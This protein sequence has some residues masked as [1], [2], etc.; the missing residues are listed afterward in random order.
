[1]G[2]WFVKVCCNEVYVFWGRGHRGV[3]VADKEQLSASLEDYLEAIYQI[4][5]RKGAAQ[6]SQVADS[7][8]VSKSSVSWGLNRL[9]ER[10]LINHSPYEAITLTEQGEALGRRVAS[11]HRQIKDFLR[12]VLSVAEPVAESNACRLEHVLDKAVLERMGDFMEFMDQCPR[13]GQQW[14][15]GFGYYCE[16]GRLEDNCEECLGDCVEKLEGKGGEQGVVD[17]V[18]EELPKQVKERDRVARRRLGEVLAESGRALTADEAVVVDVFMGDERHRTLEEIGKESRLRRSGVTAQAVRGAMGLLCEYKMA[19]A[20][21]LE[22]QVFYEHCHPESHHDHMFCVKCGAIYE[23]FDPR[24]EAL[25]A[26]NARQADFR[27]LVHNLNIYGVCQACIERQSRTR[28]L[29]DALTGERVAVVQVVADGR[30][31]DRLAG[32]GLREQAVVEVLNHR[33]GGDKLLVLAGQSRVMLD[34]QTAQRVQVVH[35]EE[36]RVMGGGRGRRARHRHRADRGKG[37]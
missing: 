24:I 19:R 25:Q 6:S 9:R 13:A 15:K 10:G 3:G 2:G 7:L 16:T 11:R 35:A 34:R 8:K 36:R 21:R 33:C 14:M 20:L 31:R 28:A 32:L 18:G 4:V 30:E 1:V 27:L 29:A 5:Q 26:Q 37:S 12:E 17:S 23:F 22:D